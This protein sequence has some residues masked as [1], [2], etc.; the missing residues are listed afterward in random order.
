MA[1]EY[2]M[3]KVGPCTWHALA[4]ED[5][6]TS[7]L[8]LEAPLDDV[9]EL[10][11]FLEDGGPAFAS[12]VATWTDAELRAFLE[13]VGLDAEGTKRDRWQRVVDAIRVGNFPRPFGVAE[14]A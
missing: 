2:R 11:E 10:V 7:R 5:D 12:G 6:G 13:R 14:R 1:N 4:V 9:F 8:L 3:K